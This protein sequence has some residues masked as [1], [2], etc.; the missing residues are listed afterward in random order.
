MAEARTYAGSC[1][2]GAVRYEA[3]TDLAQIM[4]CNCSRCSRLGWLMTFVGVERFKL[5]SGAD[6]LTEYRFNTQNIAHL[7][8][9]ICGIESFA[10][11]RGPGGEMACVNVRCLEGVDLDALAVT[12]VD[13]R[14]R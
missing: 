2:C 11:G 13:G 5:L 3:T 4:S 12:K 9:K 14:S 6:Q 8:C 1:H 10:R 7:F